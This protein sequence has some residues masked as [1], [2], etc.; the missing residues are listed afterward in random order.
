MGFPHWISTRDVARVIEDAVADLGGR[1]AETF[2]DG[3]RLFVRALLPEER[4]EIGRAHV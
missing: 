4:D 2:E 1:V 3:E